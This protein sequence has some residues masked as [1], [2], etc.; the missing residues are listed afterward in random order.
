MVIGTLR[1]WWKWGKTDGSVRSFRAQLRRVGNYPKP[2]RPISLRCFF[3]LVFSWSE[4]ENHCHWKHLFVEPQTHFLTWLLSRKAQASVK[5]CTLACTPLN[6]TPTTI[7]LVFYSSSQGTEVEVCKSY[8]KPCLTKIWA[9][10]ISP[11]FFIRPF[12]ASNFGCSS[13]VLSFTL[14]ALLTLIRPHLPSAKPQI[15]WFLS[16]SRFFL[17][18]TLSSMPH[19]N[20]NPSSFTV[21]SWY[22]GV[23]LVTQLLTSNSPTCQLL[24]MCITVFSFLFL[25]K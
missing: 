24:S 9:E 17:S 6:M 22:I 19:P 23:F 13:K 7:W 10:R 12:L 21:L 11:A 20:K 15:E 18:L 16:L 2:H 1:E 25:C 14:T 3:E 8:L 4:N 5:L